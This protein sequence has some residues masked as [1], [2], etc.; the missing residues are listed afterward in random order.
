MHSGGEKVKVLIHE[1]K[2]CGAGMCVMTAPK[3]FDQRESD[4][5]VVLLTDTPSAD[6]IE[7]VKLAWDLCPARAIQLSDE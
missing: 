3:V 2:C 6:E 7:N 5:I 1:E 4:G